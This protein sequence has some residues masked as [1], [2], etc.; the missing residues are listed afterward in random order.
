MA[1]EVPYA[2]LDPAVIQKNITITHQRFD[3]QYEQREI[4]FQ[5]HLADQRDII[6]EEVPSNINHEVPAAA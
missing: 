4:E 2:Y 1:T 5:Q 3:H 6:R